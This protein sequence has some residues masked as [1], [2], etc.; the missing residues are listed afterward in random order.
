MTN[1]ERKKNIITASYRFLQ[2]DPGVRLPVCDLPYTRA[3]SYSK[4][5]AS[6]RIDERTHPNILPSH[7]ANA[8]RS[9]V[10]TKRDP[11]YCSS[12]T[13]VV[14]TFAGASATVSSSLTAAKLQK[15]SYL[16]P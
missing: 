2:R 6:S 5:V 14:S 8:M 13:G 9:T 10:V 3:Y 16:Y 4:V 7:I 12:S 15:C 1:G 11:S